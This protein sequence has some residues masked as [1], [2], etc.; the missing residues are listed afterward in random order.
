M[1]LQGGILLHMSCRLLRLGWM[2]AALKMK[3]WG[4]LGQSHVYYIFFCSIHMCIHIYIYNI[5]IYIGTIYMMYMH[6]LYLCY[7]YIYI[8]IIIIH[9]AYCIC[10]YYVDCIYIYHHISTIHTDMLYHIIYIYILCDTCICDHMRMIFYGTYHPYYICI[11]VYVV[12]CTL[13]EFR[14]ALL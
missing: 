6:I 4:C 2:S 14:F 9:V 10:I 3:S 13:M 12:T 7:G 11:V 8:Y 1:N 5:Y